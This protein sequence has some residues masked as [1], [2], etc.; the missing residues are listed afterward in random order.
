MGV[1]NIM[2][3]QKYA[4]HSRSPRP[5]RLC[6]L[7]TI[8]STL[9]TSHNCCLL[10]S[11]LVPHT[12]RWRTIQTRGDVQNAPPLKKA[13]RTKPGMQIRPSRGGN[14]ARR[15]TRGPSGSRGSAA[16]PGTRGSRSPTRHQRTRGGPP[17]R[18]SSERGPGKRGSRR[19]SRRGRSACSCSCRQ[20]SHQSCQASCSRRAGPRADR[21][22]SDPSSSRRT[23]G[24]RA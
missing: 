20:G 10:F 7:P 12:P 15:R 3:A 17:G 2:S 1:S 11:L 22:R 23:Q 14:R 13:W 24:R 9:S 5:T 18:R 8:R 21:T 4:E 19:P 6:G 16:G